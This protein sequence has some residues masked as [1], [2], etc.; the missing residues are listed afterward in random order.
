MTTPP[1]DWHA[2]AAA[3]S[4]PVR[5]FIDG[6]FVDSAADAHFESIN[7]A[8]NGAVCTLS[9]GADDD[10]DRAV[11]AARRAFEDGRWAK[12]TP[13]QRKAVL[14]RIAELIEANADDL[15]LMD[16]LEMG[17]AISAARAEIA[18]ASGFFRYYGEATDKLYG[19]VAPSDSITLSLGLLE[20]RGVVGAI[21]PWNFPLINA[22][23]KAAPA[24]AAGNSVVLKPSEIA[25]TSALRLAEIA[26]EADL[27]GGVF[28][29]VPGLGPTVGQA[30]GRH[31]DI[32]F[33]SFTGSTATGRLFMT[34][35]GQSNG[36]PLL[37]ECG[38]KSPQLV[39]ADMADDLDAVAAR[40]AH[41]A[42]WNQGQWCAAKTRL[43]VEDSFHDRLV[44]AVIAA[45]A[46]LVPGDPLD[47][48]T[49][50][51][52]IATRGQ[53]EKIRNFVAH[54]RTEGATVAF[55][56]GPWG[57]T[58][59]APTIL[60]DVRADMTVACEEVF[61]PVLS[62]MRFR[63]FGEALAIANDTRYGLAA[64]IWTRDARRSHEAARALRAGRVTV[65]ASAAAGEHSGFALSAEP[66]GASGFGVEGGM[67]GL[68]SY[69]RFKSVEFVS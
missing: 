19:A 25:S 14:L 16:S 52:T 51:G 21:V 17:K 6:R 60:T 43:I 15:A 46:R 26:S 5:P 45:A 13:L 23:L 61:G 47:P 67:E 65:R 4:V 18:F 7:P 54:A 41:D 24:L 62:V 30:I 22:A 68:R 9:V 64:S 27:P 50:F 39:C 2:R 38:G 29:V 12:S 63:D 48:A 1:I 3:L 42:F 8:T 40:V 53:L 49:N 69:C 36:K 57:E 66:W 56:G 55:N 35:A 20:P 11:A 31:G 34:Y 59:T 32:D 37:L 10:V 44:D 28:N 58:S 33:I